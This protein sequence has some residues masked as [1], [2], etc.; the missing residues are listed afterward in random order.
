MWNFAFFMILTTV[1]AG[2]D[3][4]TIPIDPEQQKRAAEKL[5]SAVHANDYSAV[6]L[7]G[8]RSLELYPNEPL[9]QAPIYLLMSEAAGNSGDPESAGQLAATAHRLDPGIDQE[10]AS[11]GKAQGARRGGGE[12]FQTAMLAVAQGIQAY[13]QLRMQVQQ[14]RMMRQQMQMQ[15]PQPGMPMQPG[16]PGQPPGAPPV[17]QQPQAM[18]VFPPAP[19][20]DPNYQQNPAMNAPM[21]GW[22]PQPGQ[23]MPPQAPQYSQPA[24]YPQLAQYPQSPQYPQPVQ[25]PQ[26]TQPAA[27]GIPPPAQGYYPPAAPAGQPQYYAPVQAPYGAP[28]W[29]PQPGA[30]RGAK[31]PV[32]KVLHDHSR[33][34]DKAYFGNSCG[35]LVSVSGSNLTFTASGGEAPR[36]IPGADI[37][38]IRL[39]TVVGR[40]AGVFHIATRQGLYLS[41]APATSGRD[42]AEAIIQDLRSRLG[43]GE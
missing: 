18:P 15:Q 9:L 41:L 27:P 5:E 43:M 4:L 21:P 30:V 31:A 39:N 26:P 32:F 3:R 14:Q 28:A 42:E 20:G 36:V 11:A 23:A 2:A 6:L 12:R 1:L 10:V 34:V 38:E 7:L 22:A 19:V 24:Q 17:Y 16:V 40:E 25:Y 33:S 8:R 29:T 37:R 13:Q 35:A